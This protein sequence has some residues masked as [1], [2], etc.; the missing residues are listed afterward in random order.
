M[1]SLPLDLPLHRLLT[2]V[3]RCCS[4]LTVRFELFL[5]VPF[6][7]LLVRLPLHIVSLSFSIPFR[8][9]P[10]FALSRAHSSQPL[11]LWPAFLSQPPSPTVRPWPALLP[12]APRALSR[13]GIFGWCPFASHAQGVL[14][15]CPC[16]SFL[17]YSFLLALGLPPTPVYPRPPSHARRPLPIVLFSLSLAQ[18]PLPSSLCPPPLRTVP[19]PPPFAHRPFPTIPCPKPL[20]HRLSLA[21]G[22]PK[23]YVLPALL[24]YPGA[25]RRPPLIQA[26]R[27]RAPLMRPLPSPGAP[28]TP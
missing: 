21:F 28:C 22:P 26:D 10:C 12:G 3:P 4:S 5:I 14:P 23:H 2:A 8:H 19:C 13:L 18:C 7:S 1:S 6:L 16:P 9:K 20:A 15:T 11:Y 17:A 27:V 24:V 25:A